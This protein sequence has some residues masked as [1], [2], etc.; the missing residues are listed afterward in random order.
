MPDFKGFVLKLE[1]RDPEEV[2]VFLRG[3]IVAKQNNSSPLWDDI[4]S[5]I[6]SSMAKFWE[7][8]MNEELGART[9]AGM[10]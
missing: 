4:I 3:T 6:N 2:E 8:R 7:E 5:R 9:A 1:F 10:P